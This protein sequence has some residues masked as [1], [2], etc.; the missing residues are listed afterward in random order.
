MAAFVRFTDVMMAF[1]YLLLAVALQAVIGPGMSNLLIVIAAVTWVNAARVMNGLALAEA[2]K[3]YIAALEVFGARRTR[4]IFWHLL[5][6]LAAP[7]MVLFTTGVA[8]TILLEATLSYLGLG[9]QPPTATWGNM[10]R[11]GQAYFQSAPW[12]VIA[13]GMSI[14]ITVVAFNLIGDRIQDLRRR[15]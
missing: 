1:P 12:L 5:P 14:V 6:N 4:I 10:I 13:P 7:V 9:I 3:D 2:R 8:Y 15:R 11:E